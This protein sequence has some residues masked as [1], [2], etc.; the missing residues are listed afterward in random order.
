MAAAI[1]LTETNP[2]L[3]KATGGGGVQAATLT[4]TNPDVTKAAGGGGRGAPILTDTNPDPGVF[5]I[6]TCTTD[7][8]T[9]IASRQAVLNGT[10]DDDGNE[11]CDCGFE[12]GLTVAYGN[13]TATQSRTIGQTFDQTIVDLKPGTIYHFRALATNDQGP[14]Q[15]L[16]RS[17]TTRG[18][19][20]LSAAIELL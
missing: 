20:G 11:A 4:D 6:P 8:P 1:T 2:V 9:L 17:F 10:L 19:G 18:P 16:D 5:G 12:W 15:G 3:T 14:D 7:A 13:V